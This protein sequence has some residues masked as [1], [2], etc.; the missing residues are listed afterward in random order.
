MATKTVALRID[1]NLATLDKS[2]RELEA[3]EH[4]S[5]D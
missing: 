3:S 5:V 2:K 1:E 4:A